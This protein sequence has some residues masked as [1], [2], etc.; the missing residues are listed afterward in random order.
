MFELLVCGYNLSCSY[1]SIREWSSGPKYPQDH[2]V[3]CK[4]FEDINQELPKYCKWKEKPFI[5]KRR[6]EF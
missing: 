2:A 4:Y 3:V 1:D 6:S 5:P